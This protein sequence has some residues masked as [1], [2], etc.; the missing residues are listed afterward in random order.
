MLN[1]CAN[2]NCREPFRYLR[3]GKLFRLQT[4]VKGSS[5]EISNPQY[6]WLCFRCAKTMSLRLTGDGEVVVTHTPQQSDKAATSGF[7]PLDRQPGL[8]LGCLQILRSPIPRTVRPER[9][10]AA[11]AS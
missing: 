9:H 4:D 2:P 5:S 11:H 10:H 1:T 7:I 3:D 6:F 8:L